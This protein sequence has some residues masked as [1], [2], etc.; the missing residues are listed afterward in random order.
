MNK[1][2]MIIGLLLLLISCNKSTPKY[3]LADSE[4]FQQQLN[5][6]MLDEKTTPVPPEDF[7]NF[8]GLDF[9]PL[10]EEYIVQANFKRT[11]DEESF[12]MQTSKENIQK[13]FVKYGEVHF[14]LKGKKATLNIYKYEPKEPLKTPENEDYLFIPF[15]DLSNGETTYT[16]GRY[17]DIKKPE[18]NKVIIDFN[19]AYNPDCVYNTYSSCPIP[20]EENDLAI[21]I[22]AGVKL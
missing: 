1:I 2:L 21:N 13:K 22:E 18:S 3:T 16:A 11:A 4:E 15:T 12:M 17:I 10:D 6:E 7:E 20:P 19:T 5:D 9:F 8:K 14:K